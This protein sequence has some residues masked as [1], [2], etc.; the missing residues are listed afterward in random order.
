M[1]QTNKFPLDFD[2]LSKGSVISADV[3]TDYCGHQ[4]DNP[5]FNLGALNLKAMIERKLS[6]RGYPVTVVIRGN[7]LHVLTDSESATYN[8]EQR[9]LAE[10]RLKRSHGRLLQV[11]RSNLTAGEKTILDR[12]IKV[13][14]FLVRAL[15]TARKEI[16]ASPDYKGRTPRAVASKG[17]SLK[18]LPENV[19]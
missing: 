10:R 16:K 14:G 15:V 1:D 5:K 6:D 11:D 18:A 13:G 17:E 3:I 2:S 19:S 8:V 4:P 7:E 9:D 12:E